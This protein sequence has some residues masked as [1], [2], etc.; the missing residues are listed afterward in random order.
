METISIKSNETLIEDLKSMVADERKLL[1]TILHHLKEVED[2]RLYLERGY[3]SLFAF[4]T[5]ELGYSE[6]AA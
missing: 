5:A 2:R 6:S 3:S 4:I 1:T